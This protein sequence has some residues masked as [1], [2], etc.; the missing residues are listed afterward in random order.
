MED[1]MFDEFGNYLGRSTYS[2]VSSSSSEPDEQVHSL[3]ITIDVS[4][5]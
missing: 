4:F 2:E 3:G 1:D 5:K